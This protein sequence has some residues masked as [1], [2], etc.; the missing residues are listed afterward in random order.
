[1]IH[2]VQEP[3]WLAAEVGALRGSDEPMRSVSLPAPGTERPEP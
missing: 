2:P 1:M 3:M